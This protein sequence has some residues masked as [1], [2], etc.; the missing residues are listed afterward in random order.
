MLI[1]PELQPRPQQQRSPMAFAQN[2]CSASYCSF[3]GWFLRRYWAIDELNEGLLVWWWRMLITVVVLAALMFWETAL[4]DRFAW[5]AE[6]LPVL[7]LI[8]APIGWFMGCVNA[9]ISLWPGMLF[10]QQVFTA[11]FEPLILRN[12]A[13]RIDV[14]HHGH[15][16]VFISSSISTRNSKWGSYL[17]YWQWAAPFFLFQQATAHKIFTTNTHYELGSA[18][19]YFLFCFLFTYTIFRLYITGQLLRIGDGCLM[20]PFC[21][22]VSFDLQ[23]NALRK[24]SAFTANLTYNPE[25]VYGILP[26]FVFFRGKIKFSGILHRAGIDN[27]GHYYFRLMWPGDKNRG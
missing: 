18:G 12:S 13:C 1:N 26:S 8:I 9:P 6:R 24:I 20:Q 16:E 25:P 11:I 21:T 23:L 10:H 17:E 5:S 7:G 4:Q 27:A 19:L 3:P 15:C 22:V 2:V 14:G